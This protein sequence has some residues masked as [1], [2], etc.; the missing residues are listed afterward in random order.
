M[1]TVLN[2]TFINAKN[3]F[4]SGDNY[5]TGELPIYFKFDKLLN[6]INK[7]IGDKPISNFYQN[8]KQLRPAN[9]SNINYTI[10]TNK[11]GNLAWRQLSL[12][13]P[14]LYVDL[15]N[16]LCKKENWDFLRKRF[17]KF[18][19][20]KKICCASIP[21]LPSK[22]TQKANQVLTWVSK[23]EKD[24]IKQSLNYSYLFITDISDCYPSIYT[25]S[26]PWALHGE[27]FA[28]N[29]DNRGN[30]Y[31]GNVIDKKIREMS[32]NQ[33][34]GIPQGSVLMD[35]IAEMVL[36]YADAILSVKLKRAGI[37]DYHIIR[38]RDDY[39]IFVNNQQ[40]GENILKKLSDILRRLGLRLNVHKTF[41][42]SEVI[43]RSVKREKLEH[44]PVHHERNNDKLLYIYHQAQ[45]Y[46]NTGYLKKLLTNMLEQFDVK[47]Y[48]DKILL[49]SLIVDI[50]YNN[51]CVYPQA[52]ALISKIFESMG[53]SA[54]RKANYIKKIIKKFSLKPNTGY[55]C[56]WL[57]RM[58]YFINETISYQEELC[59]VL[60][61][62]DVSL[63]NNKWLKPVIADL[64]QSAKIIDKDL[65]VQCSSVIPTNEV[66][67]FRDAY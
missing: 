29:H 58:G 52:A 60:L 30:E 31:L 24:S 22:R 66:L 57:Q 7:K 37:L 63:W 6:E 9:F 34:N 27:A 3:F 45:K 20:N 19:S 50:A 54:E 61:G 62:K 13:H 35:F 10:V 2:T 18:Q 43:E 36:G 26:I 32:F 65:L 14:A 67:L 38:Y 25:H 47:K 39:R 16:I 46:P 49:L 21:V 51:P 55:M 33:T 41:S 53:C 15:V 23:V 8:D 1:A 56:V 48:D 42:T 40:D 64:I 12:I 11:D 17:A 44:I 28:K 59:D 4:L 5:F